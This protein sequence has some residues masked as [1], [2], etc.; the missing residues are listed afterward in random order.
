MSV[1][2]LTP[3][4]SKG[5]RT[6][7]SHPKFSGT[8]SSNKKGSVP[9]G[10]GPF[11]QPSETCCTHAHGLQVAVA[12]GLEGDPLGRNVVGLPATVPV[13]VVVAE[14]IGTVEVMAVAPSATTVG[15]S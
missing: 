7:H 1:G 6:L 3:G 2:N 14:V 15:T 4:I 9:S 10:R 5:C 12:V 13:I 8:P 11:V